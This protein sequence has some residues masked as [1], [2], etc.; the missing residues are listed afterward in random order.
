MSESRSVRTSVPPD[1]FAAIER[2]AR[3]TGMSFSAATRFVLAAGLV[4]I[5]AWTE[6]EAD[7]P[8]HR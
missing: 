2:Y 6:V 8:A 1:T 5:E 7:D 4:M 3:I